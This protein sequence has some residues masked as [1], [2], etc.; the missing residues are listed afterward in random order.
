[1]RSKQ[2]TKAVGRVNPAMPR[3]SRAMCVEAVS[4]LYIRTTVTTKGS[5]VHDIVEGGQGYSGAMLL[6]RWAIV[7]QEADKVIPP[8][9]RIATPSLVFLLDASGKRF[10]SGMNMPK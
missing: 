7:I 6:A 8:M 10:S 2:V 9:E 5:G 1:M 3:P 4:F